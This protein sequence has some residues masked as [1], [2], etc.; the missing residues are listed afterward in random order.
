MELFSALRRKKQDPS[1]TWEPTMPVHKVSCDEVDEDGRRHRSDVPYL[2][3]KDEQERQ[4]LDYQHALL[5]QIL[6][7]NCFA[8]VH[9]LLLRTGRK[10]LDVG[11]GTGR[12]GHEIATAYPKTHV[13]GFDLE[14]VARPTPTPPNYQ[15]YQGNVLSGLP[16]VS[17]TF[18]YVHQRLLVAAIPLDTWPWVVEE[19]TRVTAPKGWVELVEMGNTFH[20]AGPATKRFLAWWSAISASRGIDAS[21]MSQL[22]SLLK[23]AGLCNM[24]A[25]IRTLPVGK[26]GGRI[27]NLLAQDMLAG[28]PSMRPLAHTLLGVAPA[29][30]DEV[31][32]QL[33]VEWNSYH[34]NYEIYLVCGQV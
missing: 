28:W 32:G 13:Y 5:R 18:H 20:R 4:R 2:L 24:R 1:F 3:P 23:H 29:A 9:D 25:E 21:Y 10:V 7:G 33:E 34:T 26:W 30:F 31:M 22:S 12:W 19:L 8:P 11:S 16:F 15:F 17:H 14:D 6:P 27:G